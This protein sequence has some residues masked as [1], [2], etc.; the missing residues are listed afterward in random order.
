MSVQL[1]VGPTASLPALRLRPWQS[2][3]VHAV[4]TAY[5][6]AALRRWL[7]S[8][9]RDDVEARRWVDTQRQGWADGTRFSF[10]VVEECGETSGAAVG[11]VTVKLGDDEGSA[12][13]GYW[14]AAEARGRGL[15]SRSLETVVQ[16]AFSDEAPV[17]LT[18]LDLV[19]A[20]DNH[21]SCRVAER[22]GFEFEAVMPAQPPVFRTDAHLHVR[23]KSRSLSGA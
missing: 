23:H 21:A 12:E 15:I 5:R 16:W 14:T 1:S 4:V 8:T 10:A 7:T 9:V 2:D 6:D 11:H 17:P 18:R 19:H 13:V 20:V 22:C 3:D